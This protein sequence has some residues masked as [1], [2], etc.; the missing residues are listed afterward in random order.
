MRKASSEMALLVVSALSDPLRLR[1]IR[2]LQEKKLRYKELMKEV[3]L[4]QDKSGKFNYHIEKLKE[5]G[6]IV[7]EEKT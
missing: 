3:G 1:V 7:K 4:Q 6:L 5:G 2:L